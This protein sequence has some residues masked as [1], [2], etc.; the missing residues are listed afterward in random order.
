MWKNLR[1]ISLGRKIGYN[2]VCN[3]FNYD[4][5]TRK[6]H[7]ENALSMPINNGS[8]VRQYSILESE[9]NFTNDVEIPTDDIRYFQDYESELIKADIYGLNHIGSR[10]NLNDES[11]KLNS[12]NASKIDCLISLRKSII[13]ETKPIMTI[14]KIPFVQNHLNERILR[15]VEE[16]W[17]LMTCSELI[18]CL[19]CLHQLQVPRNKGVIRK[20]LHQVKFIISAGIYPML[21]RPIQIKQNELITSMLQL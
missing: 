18:S 19:W 10:N 13:T 4:F 9:D 11:G 8:A 16:S 1:S 21:F 12:I 7:V 20:M 2:I 17:K 15:K 6:K 3:R 14:F 5:K